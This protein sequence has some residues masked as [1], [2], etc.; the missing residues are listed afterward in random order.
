MFIYYLDLYAININYCDMNIC[1]LTH[2]SKEFNRCYGHEMGCTT[3]LSG[4]HRYFY[5]F[6]C[7]TPPTSLCSDNTQNLHRSSVKRTP[8]QCPHSRLKVS[9]RATNQTL[10]SQPIGREVFLHTVLKCIVYL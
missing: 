2:Y 10:W 4:M 7:L 9:V 1:Q 6:Y 3:A 8:R 5:H